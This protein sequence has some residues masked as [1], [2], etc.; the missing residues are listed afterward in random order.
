MPITET[1]TPRGRIILDGVTFTCDPETYESMN[2]DKR[3][4]IHPTIGGGVTIQ[5]FGV[6]AKDNTLRL[7]S[8]RYLLDTYVADQLHTRYRTV[9]AT[10]TFSDW[11]NNQFLVFISRYRTWPNFVGPLWFYEMDLQVISITQLFGQAYSGS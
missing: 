6:F 11:M 3:H 8:G 9:T 4:S 10:Y 5:D 2:W 1:I 7:A